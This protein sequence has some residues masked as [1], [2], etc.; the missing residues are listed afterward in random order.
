[1]IGAGDRIAA[2]F[3]GG[4]DSLVMLHALAERRKHIPIDY[5]IFAVHVKIE[6]IGYKLNTDFAEKFCAD[7]GVSL[8]I[9]DD[10]IKGSPGDNP[11]AICA[12]T[13]RNALFRFCEKHQCGTLAF[14][15]HMNDAV[16]TLLMNMA[17]HS[18][19][20]SMPQNLPI[21]EGRL[22]LIRPLLETPEEDIIDYAGLLE[23]PAAVKDCVYTKNTS[24]KRMK[25]LID[26]MELEF[27]GSIKRIFNSMGHVKPGYLPE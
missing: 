12:M 18:T 17:L 24:R 4:K 7:L 8:H 23:L 20:G 3:S 25:K 16:E 22:K 5:E 27:P 19:I 13:R 2:A 11:C 21:F 1:M 26:E 9:I 15:H 14:G 6:S 10:T